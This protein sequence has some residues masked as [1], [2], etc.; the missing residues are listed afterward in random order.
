VKIGSPFIGFTIPFYA[1]ARAR[2]AAAFDMGHTEPALREY[3]GGPSHCFAF[4]MRQGLLRPIGTRAEVEDV[5]IWTARKRMAFVG[6]F[7]IVAWFS[8]GRTP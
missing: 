2:P 4:A 6:Y 7:S 3:S 5:E 8:G 1:A